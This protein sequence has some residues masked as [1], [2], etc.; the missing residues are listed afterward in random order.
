MNKTLLIISGG[1]EAIPGIQKAKEMGLHVVV[2][3]GNKNAPGFAFADDK[4]IASTYDIELTVKK[5]KDYNDHRKIDGVICMASDVPL[6]AA[7]VANELSIPGITIES[8]MLSSDKIAMKDKFFSD[9]VSIPKYKELYNIDDLKATIHSWKFPMIIKPVDSRGARGVARLDN[10]TDINWAWSFA[11]ENSPTDRVMVEE[12]LEGPQVSTESLI[13][14]GECYTVGFSDRN[15]ELLD[16]YFP[17]VIE[18]GGDLPSFLSEKIQSKIKIL[19][20]EAAKS[21]GVINGVVK[22]DIVFSKGKPYI[23]EIATRLSGGYFCSHE[24]PLSTGVDFLSNAIKICLGESINISD[25]HAKTNTHVSQRY[26]FP[27]AGKIIKEI[28]GINKIKKM[29]FLKFFDIRVKKGSIIPETTSH[30][31]RAGLI[32]V[33]GKSRLDAISNAEFAVK[34]IKFEYIDS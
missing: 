16:Q 17:F 3:D 30:P 18:N 20:S 6:T 4:I 1:S 21:I 32:I 9:N 28:N 12:Y 27:K 22:G 7:T 11:K 24:I 34:S 33:T 19:V 5:S 25:L 14:N 2:S 31:S 26:L 29:S 10:N 13:I 8:A 23:I 15:Y